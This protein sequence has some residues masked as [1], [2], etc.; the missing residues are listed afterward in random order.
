MD[1]LTSGGGEWVVDASGSDAIN[2]TTDSN[3]K[4]L[5]EVFSRFF[6]NYQIVYC[7]KL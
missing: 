2:L 5:L 1:S 3:E 6:N 4:K 7:S